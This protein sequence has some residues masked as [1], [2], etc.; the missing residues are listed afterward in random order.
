M[1]YPRKVT[2][3]LA[4]G[5]SGAFTRRCNLRAMFSWLRKSPHPPRPAPENPGRGH[6]V[7]V[8]FNKAQKTWEETDDLAASLAATLK[9]LGHEATA[10]GDWVEFGEFWLLPQVVN[11]EPMETRA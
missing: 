11:V 7:R 2:P 3:S 9:A 8:A 1:R 4:V 10:K 5:V 6:I